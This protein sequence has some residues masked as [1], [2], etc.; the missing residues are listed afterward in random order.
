MVI[1]ICAGTSFCFPVLSNQNNVNP[2]TVHITIRNKHHTRM[3]LLVVNQCL[4]MQLDVYTMYC[5]ISLCAIN[6]KTSAST[7]KVKNLIS[8][9]PELCS[10]F[11]VHSDTSSINIC[12]KQTIRNMGYEQWVLEMSQEA[13]NFFLNQMLPF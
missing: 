6:S 4:Y 2:F 5:N 3:H 9:S 13:D 8:C 12:T 1:L 7:F 11:P 10:T